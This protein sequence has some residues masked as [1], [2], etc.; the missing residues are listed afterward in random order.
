MERKNDLICEILEPKPLLSL[1]LQVTDNESLI[2]PGRKS[3]Y[4]YFTS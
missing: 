1:L 3:K 2:T 4:N